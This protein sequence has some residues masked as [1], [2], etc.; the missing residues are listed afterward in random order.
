MAFGAEHN[1]T[2]YHA[3]ASKFLWTCNEVSPRYKREI[4]VACGLAKF[5]KLGRL[6]SLTGI[7]G[8]L[9]RCF[10]GQ[11]NITFCVNLSYVIMFFFFKKVI[12]INKLFHYVAGINKSGDTSFHRASRRLRLFDNDSPPL[13]K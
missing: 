9:F 6:T 2:L 7:L 13:L 12:Q 5:V 8:Y 10:F 3:L 4:E 1:L 11:V